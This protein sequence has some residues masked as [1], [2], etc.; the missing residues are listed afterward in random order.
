MNWEQWLE[1]NQYAVDFGNDTLDLMKQA[2]V[3]GMKVVYFKMLEDFYQE[4]CFAPI[5]NEIKGM[6]EES[7]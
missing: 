5:M 2:Y 1:Q 6:I 3:A 4:T 7:E